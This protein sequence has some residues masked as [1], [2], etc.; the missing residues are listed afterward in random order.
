MTEISTQHADLRRALQELS[1]AAS[2]GPRWGRRTL[3]QLLSDPVLSEGLQAVLLKLP[4]RWVERTINEAFVR[5]SLELDEAFEEYAGYAEALT[6]LGARAQDEDRI[7][8]EGVLLAL[9][10]PPADPAA[11]RDWLTA[12]GL[13]EIINLQL[14]T[15]LDR[16][17]LPE[18]LL[19]SGVLGRG[20]AHRS[21]LSRLGVDE[22]HLRT[23]LHQYAM[24][25]S[26]MEGRREAVDA[27]PTTENESLRRL[28]AELDD[29]RNSLADA[30]TEEFFF[31]RDEVSL[32]GAQAV[33][34]WRAYTS[35][36]PSSL[37]GGVRIQL[38]DWTTE[39]PTLVCRICGEPECVHMRLAILAT[40]ERLLREDAVVSRQLD[41]LFAKDPETRFLDSLS[42][43]ADAGHDDEPVEINWV[44]KR[45]DDG[46]VA[47]P[48]IAQKAGRGKGRRVRREVTPAKLLVDHDVQLESSD[49]A[50]L[51]HLSDEKRDFGDRNYRAL[52]AL[53][54][55]RRVVDEAGMPMVIERAPITLAFEE[56]REDALR[57]FVR[58]ADQNLDAARA[59]RL[60]IGK[61]DNGWPRFFASLSSETARCYIGELSPGARNLLTV[62]EP[63]F[64]YVTP[65]GFRRLDALL[66]K[67]EGVV[68]IEW[69]SALLGARVPEDQ[70]VL[71]RLTP[72][73]QK[74]DVLEVALRVR[75]LPKGAAF[76]PGEGPRRIAKKRVGVQRE[77]VV[78]DFDE[79]RARIK[80]VADHLGLSPDDTVAASTWRI[81][82]GGAALS[83]LD[84]LSSL[85]GVLIEWPERSWRIVARATPDALQ[86]KVRSAASWFEIGGGL[87]IDGE[88][89][90]FDKLFAAIRD[91]KRY[92]EISAGR[93]VK[94]T[95]ELRERLLETEALVQ[96]GPN[97][98]RMG[99]LAAL[100]WFKQFGNLAGFDAD[101]GFHS[102]VQRVTAAQTEEP[103]VPTALTAT[104]RPYQ[105]DGVEWLL[106]LSSW[107]A[108]GV[109]ADDMG[110]GKTVQVLAVLLARKDRGPSL[111]IAPTSVAQVWVQEAKR[112]APDLNLVAYRDRERGA[113]LDSLGPNDVVVTSY[114]LVS[115]DVAKLQGIEWSTLV[116][117]EAQ[118]AKNARS[119]RAR[120]VAKLNAQMRIAVTGTPVENHLG[121]LWSIFDLTLPGLLGPWDRFRKSYA[122]AIEDKRDGQKL[123]ALS[124]VLRPFVLRRTKSQVATDLPPRTETVR[125][126]ELSTQE[127]AIYE[128]SRKDAL[129]SL[130][131]LKGETDQKK[132]FHALA[133]LTRLRL[134]ACHPTFSGEAGI[135]I[136]STK[137]GELVELVR[138]LRTEGHRVLVFSQFVK[139]LE[140]ARAALEKNEVECLYLDGSTP[141]AERARLVDAFQSETATAFLISLKAGGTGLNL[142]AASYVI[143]LDP[144][145]NPAV[146]DQASD[147]AHRLGQTKPVTVLRL[148]TRDTV[149]EAV[150]ALHE[151]K[152]DLATAV[153]EGTDAAG[154]LGVADL[155]DLIRPQSPPGK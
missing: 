27:G 11:I 100:H 66:A 148:V 112:F 110:L 103:V 109:L 93:F 146:E 96:E 131:K 136:P 147:R 88:E 67:L 33:I 129:A 143:H 125:Y 101:A 130:G 127:R 79:E 149:E 2:R 95:E 41:R 144:W 17:D 151:R 153:L 81:Q 6:E 77:H 35:L 63:R 14:S 117:D 45:T 57:P 141:A 44:L 105:K 99:R 37:L 155:V 28:W 34:E 15:L 29:K 39:A 52:E 108:G 8:S 7:S 83:A 31:V 55:N 106:R 10:M 111:V 91:G 113:M 43:V 19:V 89:V 56:A 25:V 120:A 142:T 102:L 18:S 42:E 116:L 94:L 62:I 134:L 20:T 107:E 114:D 84:A 53:Y 132:R 122:H 3:G 82:D 137:L 22:D 54:R 46:V 74:D 32:L 119:L 80:A 50:A 23:K 30:T 72:L 121:E 124:R 70:R 5:M 90:G 126:V 145:W 9:P 65:L 154:K 98:L 61:R 123:G 26:T 1:R 64:A 4:A 40:L 69:P 13:S 133:S 68:P 16:V 135:G 59:A 47:V 85:E 150:V 51:L 36:S 97:G 78:R 104:L 49:R 139:F 38:G 48:E 60:A 87:V 138:E 118:A 140:L 152:R 115:R 12:K 24:F 73:G 71:V 75:P 128:A 86:V 92:V 58:F 21:M 76:V